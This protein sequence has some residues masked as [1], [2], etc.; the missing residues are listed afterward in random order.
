MYYN[1][2]LLYYKCST[3]VLHCNERGARLCIT[4]LPCYTIIDIVLHRA[5]RAPMYYKYS[6]LSSRSM[7]CYNERGERIC[8]TSVGYCITI[9][10]L[11]TTTN[12]ASEYA[13]QL[14]DGSISHVCFRTCFWMLLVLTLACFC[15]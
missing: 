1:S 14:F 7:V 11:C 6:A 13:P 3:S 8:I 4:Y 9:L 10:R 12:G 15:V 2:S 5:R